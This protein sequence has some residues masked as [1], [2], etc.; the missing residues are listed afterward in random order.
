MNTANEQYDT[1]V[2]MINNKKKKKYYLLQFN[3]NLWKIKQARR[4]FCFWLPAPCPRCNTTVTL[5]SETP[6]CSSSDGAAPL[7]TVIQNEVRFMHPAL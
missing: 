4:Y 1:F 6:W 3:Q 5:S 2:I 7:M